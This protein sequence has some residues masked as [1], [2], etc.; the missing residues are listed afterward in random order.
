M[1]VFS[2][3]QCNFKSTVAVCYPSVLTYVDVVSVHRRI[4]GAAEHQVVHH[5]RTDAQEKQAPADEARRT[6]RLQRFLRGD[7]PRVLPPH[8][9]AEHGLGV[10]LQRAQEQAALGVA[11]AD[12]AVVGADQQHSAGAL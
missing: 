9:H 2:V 7:G 8:L 6:R 12:L 11:H 10:T 5:L 4:T 3:R 1:Q